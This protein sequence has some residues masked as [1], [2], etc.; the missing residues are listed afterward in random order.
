MQNIHAKLDPNRNDFTAKFNS[1]KIEMRKKANGEWCERLRENERREWVCHSIVAPNSIKSF[2]HCCRKLNVAGLKL[3]GYFST[4][5]HTMTYM[6]DTW[7]AFLVNGKRSKLVVKM[8]VTG[9]NV[10]HHKVFIESE[11]ILY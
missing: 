7:L 3:A 9:L 11:H 4:F 6:C 8:Y 5:S 1:L 10:A 2:A